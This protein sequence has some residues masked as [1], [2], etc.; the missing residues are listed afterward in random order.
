M[1]QCASATSKN[2][3]SIHL[4]LHFMLTKHMFFKITRIMSTILAE[5]T[6]KL[7]DFATFEFLM[8][9]KATSPLIEFTTIGAMNVE[10]FRL[11]EWFH[12]N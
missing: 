4:H 11:V 9:T 1:A 5:F 12:R 7:G 2:V 6:A 3:I 8:T 10:H